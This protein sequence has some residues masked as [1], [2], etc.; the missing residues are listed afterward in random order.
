MIDMTPIRFDVSKLKPVISEKAF[1]LHYNMIYFDHV[2]DFNRKQG[3]IPFNRAGA[4]LHDLFFDNLREYRPKN[5]PLGKVAQIIEMRY[6]TYENF[7]TTLSEQ[8]ERIQG[9]GWLFMNN[10][11][12]INIIP[13]NRIVDNIAMIIDV[14]EHAYL[15]DY[16][17]NKTQY[18]VDALH[19]IDWEKVNER[20]FEINAKKKEKSAS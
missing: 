11:G 8:A 9:N 18:V 2:N 5:P 6:G 7:V 3:D 14:W 1:N 4:Y 10:A 19:L 17:N 20:I 15:L 13:N 12:Y 16:G